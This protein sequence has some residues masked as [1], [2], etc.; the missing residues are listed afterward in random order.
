MRSSGGG[1]PVPPPSL[2]T[3]LECGFPL[4]IF[5][6]CTCFFYFAH[7]LGDVLLSLH[8]DILFS[9]GC[10]I[11]YLLVYSLFHHFSFDVSID[12]LSVSLFCH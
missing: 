3:P 11:L 1:S 7:Y 8:V 10:I 5:T 2:W 6:F 4:R 9:W 12:G